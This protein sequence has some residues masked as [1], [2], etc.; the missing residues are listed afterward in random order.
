MKKSTGKNRAAEDEA[1]KQNQVGV[2]IPMFEELKNKKILF[3]TT[4]NLDYLRNYPRNPST[5]RK[6]GIFFRL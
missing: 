4:K 3:I 1:V 2:R 6:D 5:E